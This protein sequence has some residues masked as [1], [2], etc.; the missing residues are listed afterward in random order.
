M[1]NENTKRMLI[2]PYNNKL[3]YNNQLFRIDNGHNVFLNLD[4][5][6]KKHGVILET[7][8]R[9]KKGQVISKYIYCDV[10]Y[11]WNVKDWLDLFSHKSKNILFFFESPLINP[12]NF[13]KLFHNFFILI[14][15][16]DDS[17]SILGKN[18]KKFFLPKIEPEP[19]TPMEFKKKKFITT[20]L[21]NKKSLGL[22][23]FLSPFKKD[24]YEERRR[25][26]GY[27]DKNASFSFDLYGYGWNSPAKFSFRE[28]V[29]GYEKYKSYA[30]EVDQQKKYMLINNYKYYLAFENAAA[31]GYITEKIFDC[32]K[33]GTVPIYLGAPNISKYIPKETFIDMSKY[34]NYEDLHNYLNSIN[35]DKYNSYLKAAKKFLFDK[36]SDVWFQNYFSKTILELVKV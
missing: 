25:A 5:K 18:Y 9:Y 10:P 2:K 1:H 32:F 36:R 23:K 16:W 11:P 30:G 28:Y 27:F 33:S 26:V 8:D 13:M 6:L 34:K 21:S 20:V 31:S 12:F 15:T 4:K 17:L 3:F 35:A 29:F 7:I 14:Y 24:L 22:F 19:F